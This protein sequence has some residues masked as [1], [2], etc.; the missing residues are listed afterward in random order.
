MGFK[1]TALA[2]GVVF[3]T[4]AF[5]SPSEAARPDRHHSPAASAKPVR[6]LPVAS[7]P[8]KPQLRLAT[9]SS[10]RAATP[11]RLRAT[12]ASYAGISCVPYARQATGMNISGNG[13][14][15]WGNAAGS[16]ARG[17]RPEPGSVLAFRSTGSMRYGHVAVVS[18]VVAPRH[19]LIDHANWGGPGIRRGTVMQDVH[20]IDVSA[21]NDWTDVRVQIGRDSSSFGRNYPTYGF[22][23]N[24]ADNGSMMAQAG[25]GQAAFEEI[26]EA[27]EPT[28]AP[29]A[30]QR[31]VTNLS[32]AAR[33]V[34]RR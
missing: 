34:T 11:G 14:Q 24:R 5:G 8:S 7:K 6:A 31:S 13:W 2:I 10:A 12:R 33:R 23:Y 15:W 27:P 1:G 22:I 20:V 19:V 21:G 29:R 28:S 4:L 3:G 9:V 18:Q 16:Y 32:V 17:H 30:G 26:A 25:A